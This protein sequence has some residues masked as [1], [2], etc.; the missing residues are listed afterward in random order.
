MV[1]V[2]TV[3]AKLAKAISLLRFDDA[4][5]GFNATWFGLAG[6]TLMGGSIIGII[7]DFF[8][9]AVWGANGAS[10]GSRRD[11]GSDETCLLAGARET[12]DCGVCIGAETGGG[13]G[14]DILV[15]LIPA[16]SRSIAIFGTALSGACSGDNRYGIAADGS[17]AILSTQ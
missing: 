12:G 14:N 5:K 17:A 6:L 15:I 11:V 10:A 16:S 9:R 1:F 8:S 4:V 2:G 13:A 3:A 7:D